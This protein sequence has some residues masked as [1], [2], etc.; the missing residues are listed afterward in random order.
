MMWSDEGRSETGGQERRVVCFHSLFGQDV[1]RMKRIGSTVAEVLVHSVSPTGHVTGLCL[2]G[3]NE[4]YK[5]QSLTFR[6]ILG[7]A[8]FPLL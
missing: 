8:T 2:L 7:S 4:W 5:T 3:V 6:E 1:T